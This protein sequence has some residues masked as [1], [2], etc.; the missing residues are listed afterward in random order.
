MAGSESSIVARPSADSVGHD[1]DEE[2]N[3]SVWTELPDNLVEN[4][5]SWLPDVQCL[6][7]FRR[8][9]KSW[10][11]LFSSAYFINLWN[12]AHHANN[13]CQPWLLLSSPK[14]A[15]PALVYSFTT[16]TWRPMRFSFLPE[17]SKYGHVDFKGSAGGLLLMDLV[18]S[19]P[20]PAFNVSKLCICNPLTESWV[21]LPPMISITRVIASCITDPGNGN[22]IVTV[23]GKDRRNLFVLE[24][25]ESSMKTWKIIITAN[26]PDGLSI[27]NEEMVFT[28]GFVLCITVNASGILLYSMHSRSWTMV[29]MPSVCTN[30]HHVN[31]NCNLRSTR[32][33]S[34]ES[35]IFMV[36]GVEKHAHSNLNEI[37]IWQFDI[38]DSVRS[39]WKWKEIGRMPQAVFEDFVGTSCSNWFECVAVGKYVCFRAHGSLEV[40]VY[41]IRDCTWNW[42]PKYDDQ[43]HPDHKHMLLRSMAYQPWPYLQLS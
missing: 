29:A 15:I 34:C 20:R 32:L 12:E 39:E 38:M 25:Y 27:K 43:H 40:A 37:I 36:G 42:L 7:R 4:L 19:S 11:R 10:N 8:V 33:L 6:T 17:Y 22:Y 13:R 41:N 28:D 5:L 14:A 18:P 26:M 9:C 21:W 31:S 23:V 3:S 35:K 30:D 16:N 24:E 2:L 1:D